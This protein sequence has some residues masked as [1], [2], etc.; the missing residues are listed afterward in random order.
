RITDFIA[1]GLLKATYNLNDK[2]NLIIL[3]MDRAVAAALGLPRHLL[4]DESEVGEELLGER[5]V[6]DHPDYS[7]RVRMMLRP[8]MNQYRSIVMQK[9]SQAHPGPPDPL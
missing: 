8:V 2:K 5:R 9:L 7:R 6:A 1:Q 4:G 3:P